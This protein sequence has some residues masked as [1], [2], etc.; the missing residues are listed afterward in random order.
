MQVSS[1]LERLFLGVGW[2]NRNKTVD[3]D[4]SAVLFSG[5]KK[6]SRVSF[7][8]LKD[9][10]NQVVHTGDILT[11][12]EQKDPKLGDDLERIYIWL[13]KVG[14]MVD[15]MY[16]VVNV[17]SDGMTFK[18]CESAYVRVVN[19]DT[20]QE[21]S[22][23]TLGEGPLVGNALITGRLHRHGGADGH[24]QF[25]ALGT[26]ASGKTC[27]EVVAQIEEKGMAVCPAAPAA[28]GKPAAPEPTVAPGI[29]KPAKPV[30]PTKVS[31][32]P[33]LAAATGAGIGAAIGIFAATQLDKDTL[34]SVPMPDFGDF[35]APSVCDLTDLGS[36]DELGD[37]FSSIGEG[38]SEIFAAAAEAA[39][40]GAAV[41][42]EALAP[43]GE[44][45]MEGAGAAGEA[46][47]PA[48]EAIGEAAGEAGGALRDAAGSAGEAMAPAGEAISGA[49]A[50]AGEAMAP[51][52]EAIGGA[53]ASAG[54]AMAPA[55]ET[56]GEG[57]G[58]AAEAAGDAMGDAGEG[59]GEAVEGICNCI[60][61]LTGGGSND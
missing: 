11:G 39:S 29:K 22:R 15:A 40:E 18:D 59:I 34:G 33:I 2:K 28:P 8:Q 42:G 10:A 54:E 3:V 43:A 13:S 30:K 24:W 16:F 50:D 7:Q 61:A 25:T 32:T 56:M 19:A 45:I 57:M 37:I 23:F 5:G 58:G 14:K 41:A 52:G 53:A 26:P 44:A 6:H 49:A 20:N 35:S 51:A 47:A 4:A 36:F 46:L 17:F 55:V 31:N 1:K 21:L 60:S 48:G 27:E 9:E 12:G 38:A